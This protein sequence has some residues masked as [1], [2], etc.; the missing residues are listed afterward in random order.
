ML[1]I[2]SRNAIGTGAALA[3]LTL[4]ACDGSPPQASP[5]PPMA[6]AD[7]S[8]QSPALLGGP[9]PAASPPERNASLDTMAP[10]PNPEDM[11]PAERARVYGHRYHYAGQAY[12]ERRRPHAGYAQGA[13]A[14]AAP[15]RSVPVARPA[16]PVQTA[17]LP[18]AAVA[19]T[20]PA[21]A[22][23]AQLQAAVADRVNKGAVLTVPPELASGRAARV[24]LSLPA[25]LATILRD[26]AAKFGLGKA[27]HRADL[28]ATLSGTGYAVTPSAAQTARL[29]TGQAA[30]FAWQVRPSGAAHGPLKAEVE[31]VLSGAAKPFSFSL[32]S[33]EGL[34]PQLAPT[35]PAA[36]PAGRSFLDLLSIPG[37]K[38]VK[39]PGLGEVP[40]KSVTASLLVLAVV[41]LLAIAARRSAD[42]RQAQE[43]RR[44]FR[45]MT[46]QTDHDLDAESSVKPVP[47]EPAPS[48][49]AAPKLEDA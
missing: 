36:A 33:I 26:A 24:S 7:A 18:P 27:A 9:P 16:A 12:A 17:A 2:V 45:T 44:K 28:K 38:D 49:A 19:P 30:I 13:P 48:P 14:P 20:P 10:I 22:R 15:A 32:L 46:A 34:I 42:R 8:S 35:A 4:A 21:D 6:S 1:K 43:R 39:V 47:A 31:A 23:V 5:P 3:L 29:K 11:S 25:D 41:I 37:V 40:S